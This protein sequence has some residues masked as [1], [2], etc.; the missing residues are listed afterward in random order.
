MRWW[1]NY[2]FQKG[3]RKLTH[4]PDIEALRSLMDLYPHNTVLHYS[5]YLGAS[6]TVE[7][8]YSNVERYLTT[9]ATFTDQV[10][11]RRYVT[12]DLPLEETTTVSVDDYLSTD[13]GLPV[14]P[15][16]TKH[17]LYQ[18]VE[19]LHNTFLE[20]SGKQQ[21]Y[22]NRQAQLLIDEGR[23]INEWLWRFTQ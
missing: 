1:K 4:H 22:Y 23:R 7:M 3:L 5:A 20:V 12:L 11:A 18:Q 15:Q 16:E 13:E 14:S 10:E 17:A 19:R 2:R 6:L 8:R 9:L 21:N